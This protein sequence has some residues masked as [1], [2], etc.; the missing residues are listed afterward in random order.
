MRLKKSGLVLET[1][2]RSFAVADYLPEPTG[3][4]EDLSREQFRR[5]FGSFDDPR[6]KAEVAEV[7]KRIRALPGR[8]M[9]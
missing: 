9:R 3:L 6:F 8:K 1:V 7:R 2:A 4:P 5:D